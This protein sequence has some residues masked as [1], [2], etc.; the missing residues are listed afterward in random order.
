[1]QQLNSNYLSFLERR[2]LLEKYRSDLRKVEF[3]R[4]YLVSLITRLENELQIPSI[5][6]QRVAAPVR[7][8]TRTVQRSVPKPPISKSNGG[9]RRYGFKLSAWDE[10]M[11]DALVGITE[12]INS[13]ALLEIF[14]DA[15]NGLENPLDDKQ[16]RNAL[17]RTVHKLAN[18]K[19]VV[20]KENFGGK[21]FLYTLNP[22]YQ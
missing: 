21:G 19:D 1:M 11:L 4:E 6:T 16:L 7:T 13:G 12:P 20:L 22:N 9:P 3:E 17:S 15:N 5:T 14:E 2:E 10:V 18:K 8:V